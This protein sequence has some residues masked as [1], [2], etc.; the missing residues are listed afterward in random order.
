[1][2]QYQIHSVFSSLQGEGLNSGR[3]ATF[4]RFANCNLACKWCDTHK[5]VRHTWNLDELLDKLDEHA[6]KSVII[7]GGEPPIQSGMEDLL[8]TL[9]ERGYWI[10]LETNG[11]LSPSWLSLFDYISVSPKFMYQ[12]KYVGKGGIVKANEVRIVAE[13]DNMV[14]FCKMMRDKIAADN[15]FISPLDEHGKLHYH[16]AIKLLKHVNAANPSQV[17]PWCL[18]LQI[19]KI[20]GIR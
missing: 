3:P 11:L 9:K 7:T 16:R 20:L 6:P 10:A 1:M 18:S 14:D 8:E 19:H 17:P 2:S 15:Y 12:S 5:N 4:I 13:T